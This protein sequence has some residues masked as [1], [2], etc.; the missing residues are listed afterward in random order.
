MSISR[1]NKEVYRDETSI[2]RMKRNFP[3]LTG[4]LYRECDFPDG[5]FLMT[6]T[7]LVPPNDFTL[8]GGDIVSISIDSIGTLVNTVS[9]K[10]L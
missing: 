4:Y 1:D 5:S 2:N 8:Q 6:G 3:E 7:C 9:F 10:P